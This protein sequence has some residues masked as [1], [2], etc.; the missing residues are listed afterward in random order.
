[1]FYRFISL[2]LY[3]CVCCLTGVINER[4]HRGIFFLKPSRA[5]VATFS[6]RS[7]GCLKW[8]GML[9]PPLAQVAESRRRARVKTLM[10]LPVAPVMN[11]T[12]AHTHTHTRAGDLHSRAA[13]TVLAGKL[14]GLSCVYR[15]LGRSDSERERGAESNRSLRYRARAP[16]FQF[17]ALT[18]QVYTCIGR[19]DQG[20]TWRQ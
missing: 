20:D 13:V 19:T 11:Y 18:I 14:P 7:S 12:V 3:Y 2:W 16:R 15:D 1:M 10:N 17:V 9:Q 8:L 5:D 4:I 6:V